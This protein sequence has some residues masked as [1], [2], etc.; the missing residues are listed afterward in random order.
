MRAIFVKNDIFQKIENF[1]YV[2]NNHCRKERK[3]DREKAILLVTYWMKSTVMKKYHLC[4][5][6]FILATLGGI[7]LFYLECAEKHVESVTT[8]YTDLVLK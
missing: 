2:S 1:H 3:N 4:Q 8:K 6:I 7:V 5:E